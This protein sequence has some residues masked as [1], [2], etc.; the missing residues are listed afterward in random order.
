MLPSSNSFPAVDTKPGV[1]KI[2]SNGYVLAPGAY[3]L[4]T[5]AAGNQCGIVD[6]TSN[7]IGLDVYRVGANDFDL[8]AGPAASGRK[9][10][11]S[12]NM[13]VGSYTGNASAGSRDIAHGLGVTPSMV[14]IW[15]Q[16]AGTY[17]SHAFINGDDGDMVA[18]CMGDA[19]SYE[20]AYTIDATNFQV[21]ANVSDIY[22]HRYMNRSGVVYYFVAVA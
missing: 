4:L 19:N 2:D 7:E 3:V 18:Y 12:E 5:R 11:H 10:L 14:L 22:D 21:G 16:V 17:A 15:G 1:A 13:V 20:T 9:L 6:R 8:Y